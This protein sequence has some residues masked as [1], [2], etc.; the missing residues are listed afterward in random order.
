MTLS[1]LILP[2]QRR[3][4]FEFTEFLFSGS[5]VSFIMI[6]DFGSTECEGKSFTHVQSWLRFWFRS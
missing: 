1:S 4:A 2:G 5:N 3:D 6:H